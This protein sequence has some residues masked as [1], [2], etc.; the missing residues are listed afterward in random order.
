MTRTPSSSTTSVSSRHT[1]IERLIKG[2]GIHEFGNGTINH[3]NFVSSLS[4]QFAVEIDVP[5]RPWRH[6]TALGR[7]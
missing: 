4:E 3:S 1:H 6:D 7:R 2:R 5:R